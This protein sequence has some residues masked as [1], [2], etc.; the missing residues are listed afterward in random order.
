MP[1]GIDFQLPFSARTSPDADAARIRALHWARD[2]HLVTDAT[3]ER[4]FLGW[5]I[6][7]LMA[8]WVPLATGPELDL[9]VNTLNV[10]TM[11]D[12]Q[13]DGQLADRPEEVVR[14][15]AEF[16]AIARAGAATPS[17]VSAG[18]GPLPR[19]FAEVWSRMCDGRTPYWTDR[20][21][22]HF[23][24]CLD[25]YVE[26]TN[27]RA[28]KRIPTYDEYFEMRRR[29]GYVYIMMDLT[30]AVYGFETS[31]RIYEL[32]IMRRMVDITTDVVSIGNDVHSVEKEESRGDV[33]NMVLVIE[34]E[35]HCTRDKSVAE[36]TARINSW[37]RPTNSTISKTGWARSARRTSSPT[38]KQPPRTGS[39]NAC[40][41]R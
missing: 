15:C 28:R 11:L 32:P 13:F 34:H 33:H 38:L 16:L 1:Q 17:A 7:G 23:R 8:L 26:E 21:V 27:N 30:E 10:W 39:P 5:D 4:R 25:A 35:N 29:S 31:R 37:G 6:A 40:G 12:D 36:I 14:S 20:A 22:E 3:S 41:S 2:R 9:A 24:W 18:A 19:A